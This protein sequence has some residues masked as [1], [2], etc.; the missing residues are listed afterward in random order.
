M[1]ER[2]T[3]RLLGGS[4][5]KIQ[6][7]RGAGQGGGKYEEMAQASERD[8]RKW[9]EKETPRRPGKRVRGREECSGVEAVR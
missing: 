8:L 4:E 1:K 6:R 2:R 9:N 5:R 3:K 7:L